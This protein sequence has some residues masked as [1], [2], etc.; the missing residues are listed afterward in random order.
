MSLTVS[1][2]SNESAG[3]GFSALLGGE[4]RLDRDD[5]TTAVF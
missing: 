5:P 1:L 3:A 4:Q 2:W